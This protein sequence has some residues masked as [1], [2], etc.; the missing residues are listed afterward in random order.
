MT[1]SICGK[2]VDKARSDRESSQ[3]SYDPAFDKGPTI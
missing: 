1:Q 2:C 3:P